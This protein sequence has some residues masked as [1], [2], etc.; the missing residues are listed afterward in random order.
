MEVLT[1]SVTVFGMEPLIKVKGGHNSEA[2]NP[3]GLVSL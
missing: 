3:V 1:P 2:P